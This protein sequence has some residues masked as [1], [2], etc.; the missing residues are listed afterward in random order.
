MDKRMGLCIDIGH[1]VRVG[2]DL[3]AST[4][5][6]ADRLMDVHMKDVTEAAPRGH[7]IQVGRG[8]IDIPPFLRTLR[9]LNYSGVVS[10]E[11][12]EEA[13]DPL[14]GLAESVGYVRGVWA[15]M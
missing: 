4:E 13:K 9:R 5:K 15:A 8:V 3:I 11:Y 10:F 14:P 7:G 1:T 2:A 12:E 6:C